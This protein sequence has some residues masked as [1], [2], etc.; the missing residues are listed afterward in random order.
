[1]IYLY[2]I[3]LYCSVNPSISVERIWKKNQKESL[4]IQ[5]KNWSEHIGW[6]SQLAVQETP[7]QF[8]GREDSPGEKIGYLSQY[9]RV[10]VVSQLVKNLPEMRKT[11]VWSLGWE[12]PLEKGK[13]THSNILPG[14]FHGL[15][16]TWGCKEWDT[17]EWLSLTHSTWNVSYMKPLRQCE[18]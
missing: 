16:S 9:F 10:S 17:T 5:S 15:Y 14:E 1:M 4:H 7:V 18:F 13:A 6:V 11:W 12:D 2:K 8:P 3:W